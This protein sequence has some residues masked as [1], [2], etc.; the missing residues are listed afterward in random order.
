MSLRQLPPPALWLGL[1]GILPQAAGVAAAVADP[2]S[3]WA[4]GAAGCFY[5]AAILSFLS[6]IWWAN[7]LA[8]GERRAWPYILA[9]LPSLV[10]WAAL[11]PW[12]QGLE[13]PGPSLVVLG[14]CLIVSPAADR[15]LERRGAAAARPGWLALR[16]ILS[17]GLGGLTLALSALSPASA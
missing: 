8:A 9:V 17:L 12:F 2:A 10:A 11:L 13:W 14:L 15:L 7:A 4:A 1:A 16:L 5:A 3:R 6:G